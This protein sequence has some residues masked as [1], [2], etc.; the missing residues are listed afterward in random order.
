MHYTVG[1]I[2]VLNIFASEARQTQYC[3]RKTRIFSRDSFFLNIRENMYT[4][5]I[6]FILA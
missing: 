4:S 3:E 2:I 1:N 5:K 6:T